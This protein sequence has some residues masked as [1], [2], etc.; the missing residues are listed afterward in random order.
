L[1][2][3]LVAIGGKAE[4]HRYQEAFKA[5]QQILRELFIRHNHFYTTA[6]T[7]ASLRDTATAIVSRKP[8]LLT[9]LLPTR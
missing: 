6:M 5:R 3:I 4:Q 8:V 7:D 9:G 2:R 1:Q